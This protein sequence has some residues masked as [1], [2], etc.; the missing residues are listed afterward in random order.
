MS[1][2]Q[3]DFNINQNLAYLQNFFTTCSTNIELKMNIFI[4][5][6]KILR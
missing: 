5:K 3:E 6:L 2:S 1:H 4:V